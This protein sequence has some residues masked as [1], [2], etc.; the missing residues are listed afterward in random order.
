MSKIKKAKQSK[1]ITTIASF[2]CVIHC[3][4]T[5][6]IL[7]AIPVLGEFF[8][9]PWIEF[10]LLLLSVACGIFVVVSGYCK[11]KKKHVFSLFALGVS[12]WILHFVTHHMYH[13][14]T[15]IY[16]LVGTALVL[17][18]YFMNHKWSA[19]CVEPSHSCSKHD[20]HIH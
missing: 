10:S 20:H 14:H 6:F 16:I 4:T 7:L 11:H 17:F 9:N 13:S 18:S 3:L 5:P 1:K 12:F 2:A 8:N 15:L 19:C